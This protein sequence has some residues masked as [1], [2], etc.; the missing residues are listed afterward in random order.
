[1]DDKP[2]D[3]NGLASIF[4]VISQYS[5]ENAE[6]KIKVETLEKWKEDMNKAFLE[7]QVFTQSK[8]KQLHNKSQK[9]ITDEVEKQHEESLLKDHPSVSYPREDRLN[10]LYGK[11]GKL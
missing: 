5:A 2:V 11:F 10:D 3:Y 7:L 8:L 9:T 1:M 4:K 6:L